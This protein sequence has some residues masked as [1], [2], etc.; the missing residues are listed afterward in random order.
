MST[1]RYWVM[2]LKPHDDTNEQPTEKEH[3]L[4]KLSI[5]RLQAGM[6]TNKPYPINNPYISLECPKCRTE[7]NYYADT[8]ICECGYIKPS[9]SFMK[10][11]IRATVVL[12]AIAMVKGF[13]F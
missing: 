8:G 5:F 11:F 9:Q 2:G 1:V 10:W 7:S 12:S 13:F 3:P 4:S 6:T